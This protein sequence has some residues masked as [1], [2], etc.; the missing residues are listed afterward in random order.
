MA[1]DEIADVHSQDRLP[2]L[3]GG[4]GLYLRTLLDG[5]APVPPI[6]PEIRQRVRDT[7][8][9]ENRTKLSALDPEAWGR[10]NPTDRARIA[11]ALEVI[12]ST[13]RTLGDWQ[14]QR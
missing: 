10:L 1:R 7:P 9:D 5:I 8:V 3:V 2:I 14:R 4:T 6:D 13:G 12:L 11:R